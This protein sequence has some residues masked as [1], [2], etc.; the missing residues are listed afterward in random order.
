M[1]TNFFTYKKI[2]TK[3]KHQVLVNT[4]KAS[5][6]TANN[7]VK[8]QGIKN[9][10]CIDLYAGQGIFTLDN[11]LKSKNLLELIEDK[12]KY[13]TPAYFLDIIEGFFSQSKVPCY[14]EKIIFCACE[15]NEQYRDNLK[16][17]MKIFHDKIETKRKSCE[18]ERYIFGEWELYKEEIKKILDTTKYGFIFIDPFNIEISLNDLND[19]LENKA[20]Y[21]D[22]LFFVNFGHIRRA[23]GRGRESDHDRIIRFLELKSEELQQLR[24]KQGREFEIT[25][26]K[27]IKERLI[28]IKGKS[29][30][31]ICVT[32]PLQIKDKVVNQ[33]Y[34]GLVLVTGASSVANSFIKAFVTSIFQ[35]F[36][37]PKMN[38]SFRPLKLEITT[39]LKATPSKLTLY[40]LTQKIWDRLWSFTDI[41]NLFDYENIPTIENI[42]HCINQLFDEKKCKIAAPDHCLTKTGKLKRHIPKIADFYNIQL[43]RK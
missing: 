25:V 1:I 9:F 29:A 23:I 14:F 8:N 21:L 10:V 26:S 18:F 39:L 28:N 22:L 5:L 20:N 19:L 41:E 34:F 40:E 17:I 33:N 24:E 3:I 16:K 13:G 43:C 4:F 6:G 36:G 27:I 30:F 37:I 15:K 32:L 7:I 31:A 38:L 42:I 35:N 2:P 11:D 12:D